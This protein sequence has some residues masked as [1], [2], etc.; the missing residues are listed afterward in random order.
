MHVKRKIGWGSSAA[1]VIAN[2]VG[3]GAFTTLGLQLTG[4]QNTWSII[5]IWMT[6]GII[7]LVGAFS[8]AELGTRFPHSGGEYYFL[9]KTFH[10]FL[11]YLSGWISLTVGFSTSIALAAIAMG[12]YLQGVTPGR[13]KLLAVLVILA[14]SIIHSFNIKQSSVFQNIFTVFKILLILL[15]IV[16]GFSTPSTHTAFDFSDSWKQEITTPAFVVSLVYIMYAFSGWN[17]A[18]YIADEIKNVKRNLPIAL[19]SGTALV[20]LLFLFLQ[21]SF[22][23]QASLSELSGTVEV[24]KVVA[25]KLFGYRG[26][27]FVSVLVSLTMIANISAMIWVGPRVTRAMAGN[28]RIWAFFGKDNKDGIPVRAIWLQSIISIIMVLTSSFEQV[29]LYS[30][31]ILQLFTALT[32][33]GLMIAR[34]K[35]LGSKNHYKS[36]FFPLLQ[37]VFLLFNLW[38]LTYILFERPYE[39]LMGFANVAAGI[40]S[41]WW[42]QRNK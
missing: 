30:G 33:S 31:F 28:Y 35:D 16:I 39:S 19:I 23:N 11:G 42:S 9:S 7:S 21:L 20:S 25:N 38:V 13:T 1:I 40:L 6:G 34:W 29:L 24:G 32:V 2:M 22:L 12:E 37:I 14:V 5:A 3:T 15:L 17:A 26:G 36:P 18:A 41:Y 4:M 8:Y 10:P 27:Q